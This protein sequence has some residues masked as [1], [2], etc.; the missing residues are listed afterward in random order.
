MSSSR[1]G[2]AVLVLL[3][4]ILVGNRTAPVP[5]TEYVRLPPKESGSEVRTVTVYRDRAVP[6]ACEQIVAA[7][8]RGLNDDGVIARSGSGMIDSLE[9][10]AEG[11]VQKDYDKINTA[12][13]RLRTINSDLHDSV[14]NKVELETEL[15]RLLHSCEENS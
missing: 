14:R 4:G 6:P 13:T 12:I 7:V 8:R 15:N 9:D 1:K 10:G 11:L 3:I 5:P 2:G